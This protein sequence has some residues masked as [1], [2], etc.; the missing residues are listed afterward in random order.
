MKGV[1]QIVA[2]SLVSAGILLCYPAQTMAN[3]GEPFDFYVPA[4]SNLLENVEKYHLSQGIDKVKQGK[5]EFA[6]SEFAFMLHYFPNH[7]RALELIGDLS[8]QM[9]TPE[10][11]LRYFETAIRLFPE[12]AE[13]HAL[14]GVFLHKLGRYDEAVESYQRALAHNDKVVDY[15]YNLGL[16]YFALKDY[17]NALE[18][19][20]IAYNK[21]YPLPGLKDKLKAVES[22]PTLSQKS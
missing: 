15:H 11:A 20:T 6:W 16:A 13:T 2:A 1:R 3:Y 8:L 9:E 17:K 19:A 21:G 4:P 7:P 14:F 18:Q 5:Y 10:R 12:Q 22:W